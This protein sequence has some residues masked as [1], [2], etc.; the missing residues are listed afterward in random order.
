MAAASIF[1]PAR[2]GGAGFAPPTPKAKSALSKRIDRIG[3]LVLKYWA[4]LLTIILGALVF[5]ALSIP[6]LTYLGLNSI[7][8]PLFYALHYVCAQIPSH[9]FYV[10]GHQFGLCA[11][12]LSIYC[13]MFLGSLAF[14]LSKKRLR[15]IPWWLWVLMMVPMAW[16]GGTQMFG[17]RESDWILRM[18]TGSL[19]GLGNVWFALPLMQ[20]SLETPIASYS[21]SP[22]GRVMRLADVPQAVTPTPIVPAVSFAQTSLDVESQDALVSTEPQKYLSQVDEPQKMVPPED[23]AED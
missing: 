23:L 13:A 19:F 1:G 5:S 4:H 12:N 17:W 15:G 20:K 16:D 22:Q 6:F 10:L 2:R 14:V 21:V 11:R 8:K 7:A 9:S 18:V 3:D